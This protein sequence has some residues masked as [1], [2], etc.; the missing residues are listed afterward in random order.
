MAT[1]SSKTS[2]RLSSLLSLGSS[3]S[4]L[5]P[6][7]RHQSESAEPP[8]GRSPRPPTHSNTLPVQSGASFLTPPSTSD[9]WQ[10]SPTT[11][12]S[13]NDAF[14]GQMSELALEPPPPIFSE[15]PG[16]RPA[17]PSRG[18]PGSRNAS[19][20][21]GRASSPAGI[22]PLERPPTPTGSSKRRSWMPSR[23]RNASRDWSNTQANN[24]RAWVQMGEAKLIYD[25]APLE[26]AQKVRYKIL[27]SIPV[28]LTWLIGLGSVD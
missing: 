10:Q 27:R 26:Q 17:S 7:G 16:S 15:L 14:Y 19:P 24:Q 25:L 5:P 9:S 18:R 23:S 22:D 4:S 11:Y 21:R 3:D 2:K 8:R 12:Q 13:Q 6:R 1:G 28:G 20:M